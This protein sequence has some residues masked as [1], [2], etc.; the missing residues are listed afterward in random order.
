MSESTPPVRDYPLGSEPPQQ[1]VWPL[2][3]DALDTDGGNLLTGIT[4]PPGVMSSSGFAGNGSSARCSGDLPTWAQAANGKISFHVIARAVTKP[5]VVA[6]REVA[7]SIT[8]ASGDTPKLELCVMD[9]DY[10]THGCFSL[11]AYNGSIQ[12]KFL[13]RVGWKFEFR[14]PENILG[15]TPSPQ[16][17]C[18]LNSTTLLLCSTRGSTSV[19][20]R[21]DTTTNEYTGRASSTVLTHIN[22]MHVD[23]DGY[24]WVCTTTAAGDKRKRLDLT[25]TFNTGTITG[26][27]DWNTGDVPTS[28]LSFATIGGTEYALLTQFATTGTPYCY[29]FL[30]S[31]MAGTVNQIDRVKKFATGLRIQDLAQRPSDGKL[32]M[33]RA[34]A[35]GTIEAY[36]LSSILVGVDGATP[37][38]TATYPSPTV[39]TEGIEFHPTDGRLWSC[40]EGYVSAGDIWSYCS[41]WSTAMTGTEDN[42]YL[43]DYLGGEVQIRLNG[44]LMWQFSHTCTA[45][46]TKVSVCAAPVATVGQ[47]GFL[48]TG[49]Y[50]RS[51]AV[52][53]VP[54]TPTE[55][56]DLNT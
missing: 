21:W 2:V 25:T 12:K 47:S 35:P 31:Q 56:S 37:T 53:S 41:F 46:P 28:S 38:P 3:S 27:M 49:G 4:T 11:R 17:L 9:D 26:D 42:S 8:T 15:G 52:S 6:W 30:R 23:P 19:L 1:I 50:V 13:N 54:F 55:L 45:I 40:T 34:S 7:V 48:Q 44:R 36:D 16:A 18:W 5:A 20:Y 22:S 43:F 33:T 29:V 32:Y 14:S 51:V 10:D 24:V 39:M